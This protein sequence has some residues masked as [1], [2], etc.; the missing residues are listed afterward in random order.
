MP[1]TWNG[2]LVPNYVLKPGETLPPPGRYASK[3]NF[4][5]KGVF[6]ARRGFERIGVRRR[7]YQPSG[8][9]AIV[10]RKRF[11]DA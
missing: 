11:D 7:Y 10:M 2:T 8:V 6:D 4:T 1:P 3:P 5:H 9:D